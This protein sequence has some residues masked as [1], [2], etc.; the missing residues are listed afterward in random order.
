MEEDLSPSPDGPIHPPSPFLIVANKFMGGP[1]ILNV[2]GK[3][4]KVRFQMKILINKFSDMKFAGTHW[5]SSQ[6]PDLVG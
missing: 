6:P 5:T 4:L 1:V 2:G 3:R